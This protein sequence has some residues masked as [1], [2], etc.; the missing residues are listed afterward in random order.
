MANPLNVPGYQNPRVYG[1]TDGSTSSIGAQLI[2]FFWQRKALI[3][4]KKEQHFGQLAD[5]VS[6]PKH[7]GKTIKKYHYIPLLDDRNI[8]D[9]GIDAT[10]QH[11]ADEVT[12]VISDPAGTSRYAVGN[13]TN[14]ATALTAAQAKAVSIFKNLGMTVTTYA[15]AKTTL[16]A[17]GWVIEE[18]PAVNNGGNLYGST[19]DVGTIVGKLPVISETGGR[20]NRVGFTRL[21]LEGTIENFGFFEEYTQESVDFDNDSELMSHISRETLRGANEITEDMIQ[22]DL[23]NAANVVF[24]GGTATSASTL[25]G[26]SGS[27]PSELTYSLLMKM[28]TS[29]NDNR[30]PKDTTIISGSRMTDTRV[31]SA[32]RYAYIGSEIKDTLLRMKDYH[33]KPAFVEVK[34]YAEAGKIATGEV[35]SIGH[36][37]FIEVQKMLHWEGAGASVTT[38]AGYL[39]G[40]GKYNVYPVLIVGSNSFTT[41][42]FQLEGDNAKFKIINRKPGAG[43]AGRDDPYGKTGFYSIQ[44]F[45]GFMSFRPEWIGLIKVVA[46]Q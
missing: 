4:L 1:A 33:D 6:M 28:E 18:G 25:T 41:I 29:L 46:R 27:T 13:G 5:T 34:H 40:N 30:C 44:W 39:E 11:I 35:G 12:I 22:I 21:V 9:Q 37:R 10:G 32:S 2:P 26:N 17:A 45:Y 42:G 36:F 20:V 43:N 7:F 19:K 23:L 8:N 38:N 15:A 14:A 16:E 31:I 3:D 24:Y